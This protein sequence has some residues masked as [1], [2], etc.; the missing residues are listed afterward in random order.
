MQKRVQSRLFLILVHDR[1]C[2]SRK[3]D[4][5]G[6]LARLDELTHRLTPVKPWFYITWLE[7]SSLYKNL[8]CYA[9][10]ESFRTV[11]LPIMLLFVYKGFPNGNFEFVSVFLRD[12]YTL[13]A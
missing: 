8:K 7:L 1:A 12:L 3:K 10:N 4:N 5:C 13:G 9:P 6:V 2:G 11:N